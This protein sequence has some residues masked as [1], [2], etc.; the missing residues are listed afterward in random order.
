MNFIYYLL[1]ITLLFI[2]Y[3]EL[4]VGNIIW[5]VSSDGIQHFQ[6]SNIINYL[7]NPFYNSFLWNIK[8]LDVNYAFVLG[9][10]TINYLIFN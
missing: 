8:L 2:I 6:P 7:I 1:I 4:S 9:F 3:V 10:S 5:R